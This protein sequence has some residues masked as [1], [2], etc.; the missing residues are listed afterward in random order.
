MHL[1]FVQLSEYNLAGKQ[2]R[3]PRRD[4]LFQQ[5]AF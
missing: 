2:C 5:L 1:F 3:M 4:W